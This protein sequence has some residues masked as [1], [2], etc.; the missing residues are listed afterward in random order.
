VIDAAVAVLRKVKERIEARLER[1]AASRDPYVRATL[2]DACARFGFEQEGD[3]LASLAKL[4][5]ATVQNAIAIYATKQRAQSLPAD[6]GLRYFAGIARQCQYER[7]LQFFEEELVSQLVREEPLVHAHLERRAE[8]LAPLE[9][10]PRLGA[11]VRELLATAAPVAR[12]F[13]RHRLETEAASTAPHFRAPLRRWLCE[14]VRRFFRATKQARQQLVELLVRL[15]PDPS[16]SP[17]AV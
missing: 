6:A 5:L 14:R 10:A 3:L 11:I 15:L 13:W 7:E 17:A 12:V 16:P 8:A 4:P 2:E 1:E 9:H